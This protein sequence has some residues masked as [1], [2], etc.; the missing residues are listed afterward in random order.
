ME[1]EKLIQFNPI[2]IQYF[3]IHKKNSTLFIDLEDPLHDM[4]PN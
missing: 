1:K 3:L 4:M 2:I